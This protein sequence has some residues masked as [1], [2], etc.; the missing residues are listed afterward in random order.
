[1]SETS[2]LE[3][4]LNA[5][6]EQTCRR[7]RG[8]PLRG[9][10]D[11]RLGASAV[12]RPE[13]M[14]VICL[15]VD[16]PRTA[17]VTPGASA[18]RVGHVAEADISQTMTRGGSSRSPRCPR[19]RRMRIAHLPT[20]MERGE[21]QLPRACAHGGGVH[22]ARLAHASVLTELACE[23]AAGGAEGEHG[24]R[25]RVVG[26]GVFASCPPDSEHRTRL[27]GR[28]RRS[29][30][31]GCGSMARPAYRDRSSPCPSRARGNSGSRGGR[32]S[33]G[34]VRTISATGAD[35]T[36]LLDRDVHAPHYSQPPNG[37]GAP[38]PSHWRL[39]GSR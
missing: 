29:V 14:D 36:A 7:A 11:K 18:S 22:P 32:G 38:A 13:V 23:A 19:W 28:A 9:P 5:P 8:F 34:R 1:M 39:S 33:M 16:E 4:G 31:D 15:T 3:S 26:C 27:P 37:K 6:A 25:H 35:R 10:I 12:A 30:R 24:E 21:V 2:G 20:G 17:D